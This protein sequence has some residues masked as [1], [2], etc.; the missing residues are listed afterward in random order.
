MSPMSAGEPPLS[1]CLPVPARSH[2][3]REEAKTWLDR[4]ELEPGLAA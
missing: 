1:A 2:S 3:P 4:G